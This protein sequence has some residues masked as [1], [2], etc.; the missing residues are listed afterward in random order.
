MK[1]LITL[2][3]VMLMGVG[4]YAAT[5]TD[6]PTQYTKPGPLIEEGKTWWYNSS[7]HAGV[8][9]LAEEE[10]GITIGKEVII[11][12][13]KWHEVKMIAAGWREMTVPNWEYAKGDDLICYVREEDGKLYT[14]YPK[15]WWPTIA[16][17]DGC[18]YWTYTYCS[19]TETGESVPF[20]AID[21]NLSLDS[22]FTKGEFT[23][24]V[25][26]EA[27]VHRC[28]REYKKY[29]FTSIPE[30]DNCREYVAVESIG[31]TRGFFFDPMCFPMHNCMAVFGEPQLR[32]VTNAAGEVIY[33][34]MGGLCLWDKVANLETEPM[35][36]Q[37][38]T[39]WYT[40]DRGVFGYKEEFAVTIKGTTIINDKAWNEVW[41]VMNKNYS[42]VDGS[43]VSASDEPV[44]ICYMREENGIVY[45]KSAETIK[46]V[47]VYGICDWTSPYFDST[48]DEGEMIVYDFNADVD[49]TFTTGL[50][51][52]DEKITFKTTSIEEITNSGHKY[53]LHKA[54]L[55]E[56]LADDGLDYIA[57]IGE[58]KFKMFFDPYGMACSCITRAECP[59]LR[60]VTDGE[61]EII[62]EGI[63]GLK[64]W[65]ATGVAD[66]VAGS[67]APVRWHNLQ[68]IEVESPTTPGVYIRSQG[69]E[70]RKIAVE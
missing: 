29:A 4:M 21:M 27:V 13:V 25:F 60:Y 53:E 64:L 55:I 3:L 17:V 1:K 14:W 16:D 18:R 69:N 44:L 28:G 2:L 58:I 45:T 68:G 56:G 23:Y 54:E 41:L 66:V 33:R 42:R 46:N 31:T 67:N 20:L 57:G 8:Q 10:Y 40:A 61:N 59:F 34:A 24:R 32:Y 12:G 38:R 65:E 19:F 36:K 48:C 15:L 37:G 30:N 70:C 63:G 52:S 39:W 51:N 50:V 22:S 35:F 6:E 62:Y 7:L 47:P 5:P 11:D 26:E 9:W 49:E 43:F